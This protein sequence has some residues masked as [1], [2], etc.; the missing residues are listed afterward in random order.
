M[1]EREN[2]V[3]FTTSL[4]FGKTERELG[5]ESVRFHVG[6]RGGTKHSYKGGVKSERGSPKRTISVIVGLSC[7]KWYQS[8]TPDGVP[9]RTLSL[10]GGGH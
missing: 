5:G 8:Q 7:Y 1:R 4:V 10:K 3:G 6:L 9:A 2:C